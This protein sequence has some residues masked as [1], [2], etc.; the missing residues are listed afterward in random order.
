MKLVEKINLIGFD[1][2]EKL[3]KALEK[4]QVDALVVQDP[5]RMGYLGVKTM[6]AV[7]KKDKFETQVDTG[8]VLV[9]R[10]NMKEPRVKALLK[11]DLS[12]WLGP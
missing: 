7:L 2:S 5:F 12:K 4:G 1:A 9:T 6:V 10:A 3:V 8:S 11:P